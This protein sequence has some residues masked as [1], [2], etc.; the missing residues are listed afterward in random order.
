MSAFNNFLSGLL[1]DT[2]D[3]IASTV[4]DKIADVIED[5]FHPEDDEHVTI[6]STE[7]V[8]IQSLYHRLGEMHGP[9]TGEEFVERMRSAGFDAKLFE[10]P[11]DMRK[12]MPVEAQERVKL[13]SATKDSP[14]L[15]ISFMVY[16]ENADAAKQIVDFN[17]NLKNS[18][19][20]AFLVEEEDR[21]F[22]HSTIVTAKD[23]YKSYDL[24]SRIGNTLLQLRL[25]EDKADAYATDIVNALQGTGY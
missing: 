1:K 25:P 3:D 7:E 19:G 13:Y 18:Q 17:K 23:T 24:Y 11:E 22:L 20:V 4:K 16:K 10:L 21:F 9:M 8:T 15:Y 5:T 2:M 6:N 14:L 12:G